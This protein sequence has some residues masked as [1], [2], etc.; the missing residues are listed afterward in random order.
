MPEV[1]V[2]VPTRNRWNRVERTLR[3]ALAQRDV[4][5]EVIL[6]DDGSGD[7]EAMSRLLARTADARVRGIRLPAAGG[8]A[9]ARNA[10]LA[11]ASGEWA[12]FL[13]DDDLWAPAKLRGQLDA[14][15]SAGAGLVYSGVLNVDDAGRLIHPF[16]PPES[17]DLAARL[18][19]MNA[20]PAG[21]S[22]VIA[23]RSLMADVGG[24][25]PGFDH[26]AD[27]DAWIR[28]AAAAGAAADRSFT[29]A[30]IQH[31]GTRGGA[32][33]AG[34]W[35]DLERL[36]AKHAGRLTVDEPW[37]A[38]W[39]AGALLR[40]GNRRAAAGLYAATAL[41]HGDPGC[42]VRAVH[43]ALGAPARPRR[44]KPPPEWLAS[45]FG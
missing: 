29:V 30:Y 28:L 24:F 20:I 45:A 32:D 26:L 3:C 42:L 4:D 35:R 40:A 43:A 14:A 44:R 15:A 19:T 16:P 34:V 41:R 23:R 38:R 1:S 5:H 10:G 6:V 39:H 18:L 33:P 11:A 13:D 37:F 12:A 25:D 27:W 9:A 2:V 36:K 21:A 31:R 17:G 7:A 22:N 8:V